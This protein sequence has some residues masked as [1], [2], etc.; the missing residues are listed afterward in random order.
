MGQNG[1]VK[2]TD[3]VNLQGKSVNEL[4]GLG[5]LSVWRIVGFNINKS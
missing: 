3:Y 5:A 1:G 4:A 2:A